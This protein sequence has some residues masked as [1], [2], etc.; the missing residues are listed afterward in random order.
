MVQFYCLRE[1]A[2]RH[3]IGQ[4]LPCQCPVRNFSCQR[5]DSCHYLMRRCCRIGAKR[6]GRGLLFNRR[7]G[8][9]DTTQISKRVRVRVRADA[10]PQFRRHRTSGG[11]AFVGI[12][13]QDARQ[14]RIGA[15]V[16]ALDWRQHA[17]NE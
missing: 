17:A 7:A 10:A 15:V 1:R 4:G 9:K 14:F 6:Q 2:G 13:A 8:L 11:P 16:Q 5:R 12:V 3:F